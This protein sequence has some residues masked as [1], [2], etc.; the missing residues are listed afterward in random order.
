MESKG[1]VIV[2]NKFERI[3][4]EAVVAYFKVKSRNFSGGTQENHD[5]T[6]QDIL[7][8]DRDS[9]IVPLNTIQTHYRLSQLAR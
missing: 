6:S 4:K 7:Y 8:L 2:N 1:W 5:K 9:K 3:W